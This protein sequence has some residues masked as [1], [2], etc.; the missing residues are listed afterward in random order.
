MSDVAGAGGS[1]G[2][3]LGWRINPRYFVGWTGRLIELNRS[4]I[5]PQGTKVHG[6][7]TS[8]I[9]NYHIAPYMR[10]DPWVGVGVGY[11]SL[12]EA[13]NL[14]LS[15]GN[16]QALQLAKVQVGVDLRTTPS[17]A[18]GPMVGADP[19]LLHREPE[20]GQRHHAEHPGQALQHVRLRRRAGPLR[21]GRHPPRAAHLRDDRDHPPLVNLSG[22]V[23][24][25]ARPHAGDRERTRGAA[26]PL[27]PGVRR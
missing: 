18:V 14:P 25:L 8:I 4:S 13:P 20:S 26:F 7:E 22:A 10:V 16:M 6:L 24:P 9:A 5:L 15:N 23:L 17:V 27:S 3:T 1:V 12:M 19:R 11:R 2:L 21:R